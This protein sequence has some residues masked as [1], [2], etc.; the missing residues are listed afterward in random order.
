MKYFVL[1][2]LILPLII[3]SQ[4]SILPEFGQ[5]VNLGE[6]EN[7]EIDEASGLAA[8]LKNHGVLWTHNDSGGENRIFAFDTTGRNIAEY[9]LD[10]VN[11]R[12]WEDISL[13][14]GPGINKSYLYIGDIGDNNSVYQL[15]YIYRIEEPVVNLNANSIIETI[16]NVDIISF[17][18]PDGARDAETLMIDPVT[19]DI[20]IVSKRD[21]EVRLY[22]LPYPQSIENQITAE[23]S[24]TINLTN[25]P[26]ENIPFNYITAGDISF[27]GSE[28]ILK[29]YTKIYYWY[30]KNSES[31]SEAMKN[32]EP[33]ILPFVNS[34]DE[35]QGEAVCW[36]T[37]DDRGY[38][39]LSEEKINFNAMQYNSPAMLYYYPRLSPVTKVD[40]KN[41]IK[42]FDLLQNYPNPFNPVT[43][44]HYTVPHF[45]VSYKS[46]NKTE[47]RLVNLT[48]YDIMGQKVKTLVSQT[49]KPGE[50]EIQ[51]DADNL[52]SGIYYYKISVGE[53]S[54]SKKML[55]LK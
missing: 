17:T 21:S 49:Q 14:P 34:L 16:K 23:I 32:N 33:F 45:N 13:G 36:K 20:F 7:D 47:L 53:F 18:Y 39:T 19:K 15:K 51:F 26:E 2:F 1:L 41:P 46:K 50:Y 40:N 4:S 48:V 54:E 38:Y 43:K 9:F 10:G 28:I 12:D 27:D 24:A 31:I 11:N 29:S 25:N 30:R 22:K 35:S 55:L 42:N 8:S 37:Y 6:I 44:I 5:R 3:Y 52:S